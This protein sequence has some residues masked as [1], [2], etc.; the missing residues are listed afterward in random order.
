MLKNLKM[1]FTQKGLMTLQ[2]NN[3]FN[4]LEYTPLL[5]SLAIIFDFAVT[6]ILLKSKIAIEWNPLVLYFGFGVSACFSIALFLFVWAFMN[7]KQKYFT[8]V[9]LLGWYLF[10]FLN[11]WIVFLLWYF[12]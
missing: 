11:H 4:A 5:I 7:Q 6:Q 8:L 9:F 10:V 2:A 1:L 3:G 12:R